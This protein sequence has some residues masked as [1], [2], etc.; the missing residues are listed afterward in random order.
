[1]A[2]AIQTF[3][4][5]IQGIR[6][7]TI[8]SGFV[9][10]MKV[11]AYGQ[12]TC[13]SHLAEIG[14]ELGRISIRPYDPT[15]VGSIAKSLQDSGMNAYVFSKQEVVV[16]CP[17]PTGEDR[18]RI[19]AHIKK[20][21]EDAKVSIRNI[22][23]KCKQQ[24]KRDEDDPKSAEKRLQEHTDSAINQI[25][26]IANEKINKLK[27]ETCQSLSSLTSKSKESRR[28]AN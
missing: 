13:L 10:S 18:E 24:I 16:N 22:R 15:L 2:K 27:D 14:G 5:Q 28:R 7:G 12:Q 25:D 8:D 26:D 19:C 3:L 1:M 6:Y 9:S 4:D 17:T 20:L 23:K 11:P 21:S